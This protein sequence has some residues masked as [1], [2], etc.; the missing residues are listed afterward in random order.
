MEADQLRALQVAQAAPLLQSLEMWLHHLREAMAGMVPQVKMMMLEEEEEAQRFLPV[1]AVM[2]A[3][4]LIV[5][6]T[7]VQEVVVQVMAVTALLQIIIPLHK[8]EIS[9]AA[10]VVV[11]ERI[12]EL[13]LL[14]QMAKSLSRG[15]PQPAP[16]TPSPQLLPP[17]RSAQGAPRP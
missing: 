11:E 16:P 14:A 2:A 17:P 7:V 9:Q 8:Q 5:I 12:A 6:P 13:L 15:L 3:T 4:G 10:E 1:Q